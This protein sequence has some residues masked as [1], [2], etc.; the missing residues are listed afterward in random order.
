ME[1]LMTVM[2]NKREHWQWKLLSYGILR[3]AVWYI[4]KNVPY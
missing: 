3:R 1:H 2:N 4:V